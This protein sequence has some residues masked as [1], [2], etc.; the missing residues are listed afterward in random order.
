MLASISQGNPLVFKQILQSFSAEGLIQYVA[1]KR[2]WTCDVNALCARQIS[3]DVM[4]LLK[5][6]CEQLPLRTRELLEIGACIGVR[7]GSLLLCDVALIEDAQLDAILSPAVVGG[8]IVR[9][10]SHYAFPHDRIRQAVYQHVDGTLR[11]HYHHRIATALLKA[12]GTPEA[13]EKLFSIVEHSNL[14][15]EL[16]T[17][18]EEHLF[19]ANLNLVAGKRAQQAAAFA[20]AATYLQAGLLLLGKES[21]DDHFETAFELTLNLAVAHYKCGDFNAAEK[22]F[23]GVGQRARSVQEKIQVIILH[24]NQYELQGKFHEALELQK[25]GLA[26]LGRP[27]P[28]DPSQLMGAIDATFAN[29]AKYQQ[30]HSIEAIPDLPEMKDPDHIAVMNL[31]TGMQAAGRVSGNVE[32]ERYAVSKAV[33]LTYETGLCRNSPYILAVFGVNLAS[34]HQFHESCLYAQAALQLIQSNPVSQIAGEVEFFYGITI[35]WARSVRIALEHLKRAYQL[36][37]EHGDW[38]FAGYAARVH[39]DAAFLG[40]QSLD[41]IKSSALEHYHFLRKCGHHEFSDALVARVMHPIAQLQGGA[42]TCPEIDG[43]PFTCELFA[44]KHKANAVLMSYLYAASIQNGFLFRNWDNWRQYLQWQEGVEIAMFGLPPEAG[45]ALFTAIIL[46]HHLRLVQGEER[47]TIGSHL[48]RIKARIR[49]W[50][51]ACPENFEAYLWLVEAQEAWAYERPDAIELY[52]KAAEAAGKGGFTQIE[53]ISHELAGDHWLAHHQPDYARLHLQQAHALY[54][55]WGATAKAEMLQK[56]LNAISVTMELAFAPAPAR[57][58]RSDAQLDMDTVFETAQAFSREID[59]S[60]LAQ[61]IMDMLIKYAGAG[62]G[63][64]LLGNDSTWQIWA[65]VNMADTRKQLD[66]HVNM[67]RSDELPTGIV[68]YVVRTCNTVILNNPSEYGRFSAEPYLCRVQPKSILCLPLMHQDQLSGILYLENRVTAELFCIARMRLIE[69]LGAHAAIAI[70]NATAYG[71]LENEIKEREKAQKRLVESELRYRRLFEHASDAVYLIEAHS[72][73]IVDCNLKAVRMTGYGHDELTRMVIKNLHQDDEHAKVLEIFRTI[74]D[75]GFMD[76]ISGLHHRPKDGSLIPIE[77]SA[78]KIDIGSTT[79][80]LSIVRDITEQKRAQEQLELFQFAV[81]KSDTSFLWLD[82]DCRLI[83]ANEQFCKSL[84]YTLD[85]LLGNK[86]WFYDVDFAEA[87]WLPHWEELKIKRSISLESRHKRKDGTIF[88]VEITGNYIDYG[89]REFDFV[90]ITDITE[91]KQAENALKISEAN[92]RNLAEKNV[93]GVYIVK[94]GIF[95]Y[96]NPR[97]A[98]ILEYDVD[99]IIKKLGPQDIT[100]SEDWPFVAKNLESRLSGKSDSGNYEFRSVTRTGRI[101]DIEV[102]GS[103]ITLDSGPAVIGT[104]LDITERKKAEVELQR[105]RD[106]LEELVTE[107]TAELA[108]AKEQAESASRA[109]SEFLANMSHELRT[110]LNAIMGFS[111]LM[112]RDPSLSDAQK[113]NLNLIHRSGE[114]LLTLINDVLDMSKIEAGQAELNLYDFDLHDFVNGLAEL[115][116]S[117]AVAKGLSFF[118]DSAPGVPCYVHG[119]EGKLRQIMI[120]L[121]ANALKFTHEGGITLRVTAQPGSPSETPGQSILKFDVGDTGQGIPEEML[122]EIFRPFVQIHSSSAEAPGT[123]LGL[124]ISRSFARLM[125]GD[126]VVVSKPGKGSVFSVSIPI[127]ESS[128]AIADLPPRPRRVV[129]LAAG[130]ETRRILVV[131]DNSANRRLLTELLRSV[132]F[133]VRVAING[134]EGVDAFSAWAPDL[135]FMDIRMPVMDGLAATQIIKDSERGRATPVIALTAHAFEDERRQI[136]ASG[137]DDFI[138]KPIDEHL[139]FDTISRHLGVRFIHQGPDSDDADILM[140]DRSLQATVERLA[141]LPESLRDEMR[142]AALNLDTARMHA[143]IH[144]IESRDRSLARRL[145]ELADEFRFDDILKMV[146]NGH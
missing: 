55:Q 113:G 64:L 89:G 83:Y 140:D 107:R 139:L 95:T 115:F 135:V 52:K 91:R 44:D 120:N 128:E 86:I 102:F 127:R 60:K 67:E 4:V 142:E 75:N 136:L 121:L 111:Q 112:G 63:C 16:L 129:G 79:Y 118:L 132:G 87:H 12:T 80:M 141:G 28:Q 15:R 108:A 69:V 138:R 109:K 21:W 130:Q 61:T 123:G 19:L 6:R 124:S 24:M 31:Y 45:A 78:T 143:C 97:F 98:T 114:H 5:A 126:L 133:E 38:T 37:Q 7:F 54:L 116:Q 29:V 17:T 13:S 41:E 36:A 42:D 100:Y 32:L 48:D 59:L 105:Y 106:H 117:R 58:A 20:S 145:K 3:D 134:Q 35:F 34:K 40:N 82:T 131:E 49:A 84:G 14:S 30:T 101:I 72:G 43:R 99:D 94:D 92:F 47:E 144:S 18:E 76:G 23:T 90:F 96:V 53:A 146:S 73:K 33:E 119:D 125:G 8:L 71:R 103:Y 85:E 46:A 62:K 137:C 57:S 104:M 11:M 81:E 9:Q 110:P 1:R 93:A 39:D 25:E 26:L 27:V 50:S 10:N 74:S 2:H 56:A 122:E 77:I 22:L 88:P 51:K 66:L 70:E 65:S 68:R